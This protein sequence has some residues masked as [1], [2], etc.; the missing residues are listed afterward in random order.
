VRQTIHFF[1][2]AYRGAP[3]LNRGALGHGLVG[4]CLNLALD[5]YSESGS[6]ND[7]HKGTLKIFNNKK[8]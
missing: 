7:G 2:F 4:L 6:L 1:N 5:I 8:S 3:K